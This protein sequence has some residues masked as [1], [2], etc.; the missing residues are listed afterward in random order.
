[1]RA[2]AVYPSD[3][4]IELVDQEEPGLDAPTDVKLRVLEVGICGT[5]KEIAA[6]AYGTPPSGSDYLVIGHESLSEVVDVGDEVESVAPGDLAVLSVRRPCGE[7][8]CRAC[9]EGRQDFC[10][11]GN[12]RERGI[13][14][15]HGFMTE[16]VV[17]DQRYVNRVPHE[18]RDI[19]ILV[20]PLTIAEK[21]L[22]QIWLIQQR[23]PW[24]SGNEQEPGAGHNALVL[25]AGPVGLLG[26]MAL[27]SA[28]F[29]TYVY[30]LETRPSPKVDLIESFDVNYV[31][32][33]DEPVD[34]LDQIIGNVDVVYEAVGASKL[35][36][37]VMAELGTNGIFAFTGVPGRKAPIELDSDRIMRNLVLKN[38][39]AFG[40]VN[41]GPEAFAAAIRDLATFRERWPDAVNKLIT[42]RYP[43]EGHRELLLGQAGGI[44]NVVDVA[45]AA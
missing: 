13:K 28:G 17:D 5:D 42:G 29:E 39:V 15:A 21:A 36:F 1:M 14:E 24:I 33:R 34:R 44:K 35:A 43:M 32:A 3:Q 7:E 25:G 10:I 45:R 12:F 4:R 16:L 19:A 38:Q 20:E 30:S 37:D 9:N 2:V 41:A 18:L 23:L 11:T 26:A 40:T 8:R 22:S 27:R 6:F 31:S